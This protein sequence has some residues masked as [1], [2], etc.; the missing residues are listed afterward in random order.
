MPKDSG[1]PA[2]SQG[3]LGCLVPSVVPPCQRTQALAAPPAGA[4]L[5]ADPDSS[6]CSVL[7]RLFPTAEHCP[8]LQLPHWLGSCSGVTPCSDCTLP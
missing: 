8:S 3:I 1:S 7:H 4:G 6:Q 5:G 2:L